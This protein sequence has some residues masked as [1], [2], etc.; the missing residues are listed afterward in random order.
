MNK[1]FSSLK[2]SIIV[3][4]RL[5]KRLSQHNSRAEQTFDFT[6]TEYIICKNLSKRL[7]QHNLRAE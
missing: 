1:H 3:C 7:S 6:Q 4:K 2:P 5:I